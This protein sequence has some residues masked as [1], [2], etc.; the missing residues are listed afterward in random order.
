MNPLGRDFSILKSETQMKNSAEEIDELP[1][2]THKLTQKQYEI[3]TLRKLTRSL[4]NK[5]PQLST[6]VLKRAARVR[7]LSTLF[8]HSANTAKGPH[9]NVPETEEKMLHQDVLKKCNASGTH[10]N[11][12]ETREKPSQ[13][14]DSTTLNRCMADGTHGNDPEAREKLS[15]NG[16]STTQN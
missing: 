7:L 15:V 10:G 6:K 3:K 13:L 16:D 1:K 11:D 4:K 8:F 9:G 14:G 12:P 5:L 2:K